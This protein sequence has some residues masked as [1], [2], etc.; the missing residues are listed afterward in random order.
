MQCPV[1]EPGAR[2]IEPC[3][4]GGE[5]FREEASKEAEVLRRLEERRGVRVDV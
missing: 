2:R 4:A 5:R 3:V 1:D